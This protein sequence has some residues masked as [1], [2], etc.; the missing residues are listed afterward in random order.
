MLK[1]YNFDIVA[2][3]IPDE[4]TLAINIT[5]CPIHCLGCHSPW[6]W[7]DIGEPLDKESLVEIAA[8]YAEDITCICFMGGDAAP[9]EVEALAKF[10]RTKWP[11]LKICW[12]SGRDEIPSD[13]DKTAY[14]YIKIG[15]Y[16]EKLGGLKSPTTNQRIYKMGVVGGSDLQEVTI[17]GVK[18]DE[19]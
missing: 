2:Q 4:I 9:K 14:N 3:E 6:L 19:G 15:H 17:H 10:V 11:A 13:I 1:Y 16:D 8:P 5:G 7:E 18:I 12:Y